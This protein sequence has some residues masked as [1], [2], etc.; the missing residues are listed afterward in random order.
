MNAVDK[1]VI[2][3]DVNFIKQG[4]INRNRI[5]ANGK[6]QYINLPMQGA[7]SNKLI[8][9]VGVNNSPKLLAKLMRTIEMAYRKAP[10]FADVYPL[11]R[12]CIYCGKENVAD[13]ITE[14]FYIVGEYLDIKTKL[15]H[16]STLNKD[17][18][19]K[20]QDKILQICK[21]LQ[22]DEYYNAIGGKKLYQYERFEKEGIQLSFL[23]TK[24]IVYSQYGNEF[25]P[26]LSIIDVMMHNSREDIKKLLGEFRIERN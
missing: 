15:I 12:E 24:D 19:L 14:S 26:E 17:C 20:A 9:E 25:V 22:A 1:Y 10:Y 13:F 6:I 21:L 18:T 11:L 3:D 4:W 8:M 7:S 16:S 2:Y 23:R 5:L